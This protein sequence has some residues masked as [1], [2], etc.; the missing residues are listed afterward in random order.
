MELGTSSAHCSNMLTGQ[1][2]LVTNLEN[3][4]SSISGVSTDEEVV[5]LLKYQH[6]YSAASRLI[7][8]IDEAL[9]KLINSTG[10]VGR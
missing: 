10:T 8:A 9:D 5:E 2:S 1:K 6:M 3:R 4:K 7:T